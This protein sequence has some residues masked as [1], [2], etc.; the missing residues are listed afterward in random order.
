M[1]S[2][3]TKLWRLKYHRENSDF[4]FEVFVACDLAGEAMQTVEA[5]DKDVRVIEHV[6]MIKD[7]IHVRRSR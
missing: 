2:F 4:V 3:K 7:V 1:A 5:F 6:E